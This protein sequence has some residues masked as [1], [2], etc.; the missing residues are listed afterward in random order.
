MGFYESRMMY[1]S[2]ELR[3]YEELEIQVKQLC[4]YNFECLK[5]LFAMGFTLQPPEAQLTLNQATKLAL[6]NNGI[7]E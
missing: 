3:R 4:G 6:I 7:K 5:E 2:Q 1:F